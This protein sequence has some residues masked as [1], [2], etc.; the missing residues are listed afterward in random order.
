MKERSAA[1]VLTSCRGWQAH[2]KFV[3][4]SSLP[5]FESR[6]PMFHRL[7]A[8]TPLVPDPVGWV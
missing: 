3:A 8:P 7:L 4:N 2:D 6:W 5:L 1:P